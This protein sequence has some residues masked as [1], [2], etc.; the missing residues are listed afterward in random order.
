[1]RGPFDDGEPE[2]AQPRPDAEFT[3]SNGPLLLVFFGVVLACGL[4][5]GAGYAVG[6]HSTQQVSA[7]G[8]PGGAQTSLQSNG[9]LSKPSARAQAAAPPSS[10]QTSQPGSTDLEQSVASAASPIAGSQGSSPGP[11]ADSSSGQPQVRPAPPQT[12]N[13]PQPSTAPNVA[14]ALSP[15]VPLVVQIAAVANSEDAD[16]LVNALRK[17]GYAVTARRDPTDN[18][19]HVRIGPFGTR[20][21][22]DQW[23][24]KL[25]ND[26]Y[27]AIVQP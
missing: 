25:L 4:C 19:I 3:L 20:N 11:P 7:A 15:A 2:P 23:R 21:I 24:Q 17:R 18:L 5:F 14:P 22:A 9:S 26:G 13:T 27:N 10:S 16:V 6:R 1:M 12:G 8:Q